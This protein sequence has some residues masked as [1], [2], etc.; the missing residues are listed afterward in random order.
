M[1]R[2]LGKLFRETMKSQFE[3]DLYNKSFSDHLVSDDDETNNLQRRSGWWMMV[4][5]RR[6]P[7]H[8]NIYDYTFDELY[9]LYRK[10]MDP[11]MQALA[12]ELRNRGVIP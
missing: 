8:N 1:R 7:I 12:K 11:E 9:G 4:V 5:D 10:V 3:Y 6:S 2:E